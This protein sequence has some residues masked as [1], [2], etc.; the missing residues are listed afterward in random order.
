MTIAIAPDDMTEPEPIEDE[1]MARRITERD[2]VRL[3]Q[4]EGQGAVAKKIVATSIQLEDGSWAGRFAIPGT[5]VDYCRNTQGQVLRFRTESDAE[6]EAMRAAIALFNRPREHLMQFGNNRMV[7]RDTQ[8][9]VRPAKMTPAEFS[10][11]MRAAN[12][13]T[14][15]LVFLLDKPAKRILDW[16]NT[17]DIPHEVHLLLRIFAKHDEAVDDAFELTNMAI[18]KAVEMKKGH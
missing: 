11:A 17:G 18:D 13:D 7:N 10:E 9:G 12:L 16:S 1:D 2:L 4:A 3:R 14:G 6:A 5:R 15:D 8:G